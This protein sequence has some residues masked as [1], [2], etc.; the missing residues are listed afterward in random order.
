MSW[1][2]TTVAVG[3]M[4]AFVAF[5]HWLTRKEHVQPQP[6]LNPHP[7]PTTTTPERYPPFPAKVSSIISYDDTLYLQFEV[8][9][10]VTVDDSGRLDVILSGPDVQRVI[11]IVSQWHSDDVEFVLRLDQYVT[12][13]EPDGTETI[14]AYLN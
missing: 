3:V 11:D 4:G 6:V 7:A 5:L 10:D 1:T 2:S 14:L 9:A 12:A 8:P 13:I